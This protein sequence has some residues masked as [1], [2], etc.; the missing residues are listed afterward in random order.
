VIFVFIACCAGVF[1]WELF[2]TLALTNYILKC[3]IEAL[4][5][6][7]TYTVTRQLKKREGIDVY[8]VGVK[9][10]PIG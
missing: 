10:R 9:Y 2:I 8:D 6:P 4:V 5:L 1:G 7:V 3:L